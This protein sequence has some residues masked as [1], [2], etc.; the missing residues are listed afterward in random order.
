MNRQLGFLFDP[1]R[2]FG[3][4]ACEIACRNEN[5]Q[6][7]TYSWRRVSLTPEGGY[8]SVSCNH[9]N[10]PEC[11]RV[12]PQ[13]AFTKNSDGIVEINPDLCNGCGICIS[14]CPYGAPQMDKRTKKISKCQLCKHRLEDG[15]QPACVEACSTKALQLIDI[16]RSEKIHFTPSIPGFPD[17]RLTNPSIL[18]R[19]PRQKQRFWLKGEDD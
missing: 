14:A 19:P 15:L 12:C 11:F 13:R 3:C 4:K 6:E 8:L 5:K 18:F 9:C 10:S 16:N 17:I 7:T 1:E 2:C